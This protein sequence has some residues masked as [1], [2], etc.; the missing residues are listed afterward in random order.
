MPPRSIH[1][2]L[3]LASVFALGATTALVSSAPVQASPAG[4]GNVL[5]ASN[6]TNTI[7]FAG[8]ATLTLT[9]PSYPTPKT[10]HRASWSPDGSR[11][12]FVTE[13]GEIATIRHNDGRNYWWM[14]PEHDPAEPMVQRSDPSYRGD[15]VGVLWAA[16]EA[17]QPWRLE[18]QVSSGGFTPYVISPQD[19]F[20]YLAP[21]S[22]PDETF[23]YQRQANSGGTPTG[24]PQVGVFTA[25]SGFRTILDNASNPAMAP[26]GKKVAFIRSDGTYD[27]VW[28]AN[29]DG[30]NVVQVT[31]NATNH[32][33]PTWSPD[34][35]T[36]AFTQG[37]GVATAPADGSGASDPTVV[38]GL[39]GVPAY[40]P[41]RRDQVVRLHGQNR[42]TTATAVSQSHWATASD[43]GDPRQSAEAVVLSRSDVFADALG[44]AALAAAKTGPLLMTP[45]TRL[46]ATTQAE[47]QRVLAPGKTVYLLGSTGALST[48]VENQIKALG[49]QVR[50]LAGADRFSTSIAI[51]NEIDPTPDMVLAATGIDFPDALA[52]GAAAGSWNTPGSDYSAVVVLTRDHT[53]T[54]SVS[55]YL[56][57]L[58]DTSDVY[59]IGRQ[60]AIATQ[61]YG[62]L[63]IYGANRYET[64]YLTG[65]VFFGGTA[66]A[67]IATGTNWPDALAGGALMAT[68]NGPLL[69]TNG[70]LNTLST[71]VAW[72]LDEH[73]GSVH[74]GL[75]FG[76]PPVVAAEQVGQIGNWLSGPG[77]Y[78]AREN[79]TDVGIIGLS[80]VARA[81]AAQPSTA[82]ERRTPR[83]VASAAAAIEERAERR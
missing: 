63:A 10:I 11:A 5:S 2:P 44:G 40:Q 64:A 83:D 21:D 39:S 62:S 1:R 37:G 54:P 60:G 79:A 73:S 4:S 17:G 12:I 25:E 23:V 67:G 30:S 47:I 9:N 26:N 71:E 32:D 56:D 72:F 20:H 59:G 80:G 75:V 29:I 49:Y 57:R 61:G 15:G 13:N 45:P 65:W 28:V 27:Q 46:D 77:G 81:S 22:G 3:A 66:H 16:K 14:S 41:R 36:I 68:I 52:A 42:F 33:H 69:L 19:G 78:D 24:Q 8:G 38:S 34:G 82:T 55:A 70:R 74:T 53:L 48:T 43:P 35:S 18:V 51:A 58:P 50:R 6:G 31:A 76:S 7:R